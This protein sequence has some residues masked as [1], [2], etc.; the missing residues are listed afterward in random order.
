M[1]LKFKY[2][3]SQALQEKKMFARI[4]VDDVIENALERSFR[5]RK[6]HRWH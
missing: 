1:K 2:S 6:L 3:I 4:K 5:A